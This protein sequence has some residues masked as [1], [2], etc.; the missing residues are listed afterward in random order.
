MNY[1]SKDKLK[2]CVVTSWFPNL[3]CP[4]ISPF[5]Y[6]F[7]Q[8]LG[9]SGHDVSVI[10]P[11]VK[12]EKNITKTELITIY[13]VERKLPFFQIY[14][15]VSKIK[16]DIIHVQA[17]NFFSVNAIVVG[18]LKN[19]PLVATIHRAEIDSVSFPISIFRKYALSKF[20][21]IIA[22]SQF[23]KSL[24]V[25]AGVQEYKIEVIYNSCDDERFL[26]KEKNSARNKI[27]LPLDKKI[28]LFVGNLVKVKGVYTLIE[29]CKMLNMLNKN[30]LVL[31]IGDGEDREK[32]QSL[33]NSYGLTNQIRFLG[34]QS[35]EQLPDYYNA[36][37]VFV[38]PSLTEGHSVALLE[39]MASGLPVILSKTGGNIESIED[40]VEGYFF[41]VND[42]KKL[43]D[44]IVKLIT[45]T[46]LCEQISL[47]S[48]DRYDKKFSTVV[49]MENHLKLYLTILN[50]NC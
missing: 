34:W 5:V 47:Q 26:S 18:K 49:Q 20:N 28:I 21:K 35:Q 2:I 31:I 27:N 25:K 19:I 1:S 9:K 15:L 13:R 48:R 10:V 39:A 44:K 46:K 6:K 30:F 42:T 33:T 12:G 38:L 7:V 43:A 16:P 36:A 22:V 17:P 40:N 37:D 23:T 11:K 41:E 24:A 45:D 4:T 32:L 3:N 29:S 8:N 14:S 50:K